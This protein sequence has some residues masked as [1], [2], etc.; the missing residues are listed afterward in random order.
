MQC[1]Q[2]GATITEDWR[3][4]P[5]CDYLLVAS[6]ADAPPDNDASRGVLSASKIINRYLS[7]GLSSLLNKP[8]VRHSLANLHHILR[9]NPLAQQRHDDESIVVIDSV[10][11]TL[12]PA[13]TP[14]QKPGN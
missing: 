10:D 4:C 12:L 6:N 1:P 7:S 2:C 9:R 13:V 11:T 14:L 3:Q 8:R 5:Y